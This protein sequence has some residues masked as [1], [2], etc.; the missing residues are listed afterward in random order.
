MVAFT[1]FQRVLFR[2]IGDKDEETH[3]TRGSCRFC[4]SCIRGRKSRPGRQLRGSCS[5]FHRSLQRTHRRA[6]HGL[7]CNR[8]DFRW[9]QDCQAVRL[10]GV[11]VQSLTNITRR[12]FLHSF[13]RGLVGAAPG[14]VS[15]ELL[16]SRKRN[17]G[18][19]KAPACEASFVSAC[20]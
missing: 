8:D 15:G 1:R 2:P 7:L 18:P 11:G 14:Q 10:E 9:V 19:L 12:R 16:T 17:K 6:S 3:H 13:I 5:N 20:Q 4:P